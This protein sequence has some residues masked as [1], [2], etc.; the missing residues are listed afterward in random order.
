MLLP[1]LTRMTITPELSLFPSEWE[2]TNQVI[3]GIPPDSTILVVFEYDPALAGELEAAAAPLIN[4]LLTRGA[5]LVLVSTSPIGSALGEKFIALTQTA[6]AQDDTLYTNLGYLAGGP[7]GIQLFSTNPAQALPLTAE[8]KPAWDTPGLA[9][10]Q[11]LSDFGSVI[12]LTDNADTGR[13]WI[14][15]T[16]SHIGTVPLLMVISAQAEPML[17]PYFDSGQVHG[18]ITGLMGGKTYEQTYAAPGLARHYWDAFGFGMLTA[19]ILIA[20]GSLWS[21]LTSWS[22]RKKAE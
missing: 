6:P 7:A 21:V 12:I 15:Q 3:Q 20:A 4:H 19:V 11:R 9:R 18:L 8:G 17:R 1:L 5:R 22:T 16:K 14:E 2:K 10:I 13:L